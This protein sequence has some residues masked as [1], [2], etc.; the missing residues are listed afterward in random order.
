MCDLFLVAVG[1]VKQRRH[2]PMRWVPVEDTV[3]AER[4]AVSAIRFYRTVEERYASP[5]THV[6]A[7][8]ALKGK[9]QPAIH[10]HVHVVGPTCMWWLHEQRAHV[11]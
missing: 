1:V 3:T 4:D 6:K 9:E 5:A 8:G 2:S 10:E 7:L 11:A